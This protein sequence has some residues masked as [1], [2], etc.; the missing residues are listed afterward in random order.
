M[1]TSFEVRAIVY[2]QPKT[3]PVPIVWMNQQQ[4]FW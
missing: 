3:Y 2:L 4:I 1:K